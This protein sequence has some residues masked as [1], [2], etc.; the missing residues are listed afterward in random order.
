MPQRGYKMDM[1]KMA[2]E[3]A[4]T[5]LKTSHRPVA[6]QIDKTGCGAVTKTS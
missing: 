4:E 1:I 6:T 5:F 3:N 2:H